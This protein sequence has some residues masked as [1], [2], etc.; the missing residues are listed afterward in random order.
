MNTS[1]TSDL[2]LRIG[3]ANQFV[4]VRSALL[5]AGFDEGTLSRALKIRGLA[6]LGTLKRENIDLA[7]LAPLLAAFIKLFLLGET[8]PG[9]EFERQV[10]PS[11]LEALLALDL[12]RTGGFAGYD[13]PVFLYP[14][15]EFL[16][17]SDRQSHPDGSPY[18][19]PADMVF[20]AIFPGTR[21]FLRG[22]TARPGEEGLDL[23]SGTGVG[24]LKLSRHTR[25]VVA[26]DITERSAHFMRFN[27]A[28]NG[29]ANVE[30]AVGDLYKAVGRRTFDRIIAHP[31]YVPSLGDNMIFRDGGEAGETILRRMVEGLP[32]FLRPGGTFYSMGVGLDTKEGRFETRVRQWLGAAHEQFDVIF[33]AGDEKSPAQAVRDIVERG[34]NIKSL[35]PERLAGAFHNLGTERLVHGALLIHRRHDKGAAPWTARPR[36]SVETAGEDFDRFLDWH[37]ACARPGFAESLAQAKPVLSPHLQVK[38]THEVRERALTPADFMLESSRPFATVTRVD[39]WIVPLIARFDGHQTT[40]EVHTTASATGEIPPSFGVADFAKLVALLVERGC[41]MVSIGED[42]RAAGNHESS[43]ADAR[44]PRALGFDS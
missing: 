25:R 32:D 7:S 27:A 9:P 28:L 12:V 8:A 23:C 22:V 24:A 35:D 18:V 29:C 31:P 13:T 19:A 2:P 37:L 14:V 30:A 10:S 4:L 43:Q 42:A 34:R 21:R 17:V 3:D 11:V 1:S 36:L 38:V 44:K 16:I 6:E 20:A 41:L 33:A 5:A 40:Q 15:E 26:S 39:P